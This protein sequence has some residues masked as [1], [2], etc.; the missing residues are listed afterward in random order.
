MYFQSLI[1]PRSSQQHVGAGAA[2]GNRP[3]TPSS[4]RSHRSGSDR[5]RSE[6]ANTVSAVGGDPSSADSK[7][8][9]TRPRSNSNPAGVHGGASPGAGAQQNRQCISPCQPGKQIPSDI[10]RRA[11]KQVVAISFIAIFFTF[12]DTPVVQVAQASRPREAAGP[13]TSPVINPLLST[14]SCAAYTPS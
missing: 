5:V 6:R 2:G 11:N 13:K 3:H 12:Q 14:A 8:D 7:R 9:T 1:G 4:I 10:R